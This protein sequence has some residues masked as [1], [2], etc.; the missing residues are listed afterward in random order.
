M[1]IGVSRHGLILA[2][3]L[4]YAAGFRLVILDRP[5]G[6]DAEGASASQYGILARNYLRFDWTETRGLPVLTVGHHSTAPVVLYPDHPPLIPLLIVPFYAGFGVGE[7]QTRLPIALMTIAAIYVL[8]RVLARTTTRR[9]GVV[10]AAVFAASPM[11]LY[12]GGMPDVIGTPSSSSSCSQC[13]DTCGFTASLD[14]LPS[15]H[16]SRHRTRRLVRLAGL[17]DRSCLS[18]SFRHNPAS[19]RVAV[20]CCICGCR[21]RAVRCCVCLHCTRH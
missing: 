9:A 6:Y 11:T 15:C 4:L 20:D 7:W 1:R 16:S 19:H 8:Y 3:V 14:C 12:F 2:L 21:L 5:F 10:A 18:R 17:R 13:S